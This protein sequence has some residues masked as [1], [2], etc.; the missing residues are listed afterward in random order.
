MPEEQEKPL[1]GSMSDIRVTKDSAQYEEKSSLRKKARLYWDDLVVLWA[2][3]K[4]S[5]TGNGRNPLK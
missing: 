1:Q 3:I 4:Y 2:V 5:F